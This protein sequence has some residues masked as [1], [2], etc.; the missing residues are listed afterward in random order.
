MIEKF[1]QEKLDFESTTTPEM[2]V[3]T[4]KPLWQGRQMYVSVA[5]WCNIFQQNFETGRLET[6]AREAELGRG[7][8]NI[9]IEVP[10][11]YIGPHK[12]GEHFSLS[13]SLVQIVHYP[14]QEIIK[15][16]KLKLPEKKGRSR[17]A[18]TIKEVKA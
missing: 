12:G 13:L 11:I 16:I 14:E 2:G 15:P 5:P 9:S 3:I 18:A 10:H 6:L 8:F 1:A 17:N 4:Y 7:T